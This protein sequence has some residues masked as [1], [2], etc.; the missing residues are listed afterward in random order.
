M[1]TGIEETIAAALT[2]AGFGKLVDSASNTVQGVDVLV[3]WVKAQDG[4]KYVANRF[5]LK[6]PKESD[7]TNTESKPATIATPSANKQSS[8]ANRRTYSGKPTTYDDWILSISHTRLQ[9]AQPN[10]IARSLAG[11]AVLAFHLRRVLIDAETEAADVV[12]MHIKG[13]DSSLG[14]QAELNF[15][16]TSLNDSNYLLACDGFVNPA[17]IGFSRLSAAWLVPFGSEVRPLYAQITPKDSA[18]SF[19]TPPTISIEI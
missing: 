19:L 8:L 1:P 7:D 16:G 14:D 13:F 9:T 6:A 5:S 4:L 17:G 10:S 12:L 11:K 2:L 18:R 15:G 3:N